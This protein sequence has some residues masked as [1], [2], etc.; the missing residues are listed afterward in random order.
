[1][2]IQTALATVAIALVAAHSVLGDFLPVSEGKSWKEYCESDG[3]K[4]NEP[5][6]CV[7]APACFL[8]KIT[9][10]RDFKGYLSP[11]ASKFV[12]LREAADKS[13]FVKTDTHTIEVLPFNG[14]SL[15]QPPECSTWFVYK[16]GAKDSLDHGTV[17]QQ[18]PIV[19]PSSFCE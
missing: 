19:I 8:K 14:W 17:C 3:S 6:A 9:N 2:K 1:M 10:R 13:A 4:Q 12:V 11:D 5:H 7:E 16:N 15:G 18:R